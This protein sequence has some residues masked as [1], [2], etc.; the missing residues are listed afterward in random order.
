[1]SYKPNIDGNSDPLH[2]PK[3]AQR[4][5]PAPKRM[6]VVETPP[7]T[8]SFSDDSGLRIIADDPVMDNAFDSHVSSTTHVGRATPE[9]KP[10]AELIQEVESKKVEVEDEAEEQKPGKVKSFFKGMFDFI[11]TLFIAFLVALSFR[12]FV[13][14]LYV[15][16]TGSMLET[17]QEED[18]VAGEK[19]S[20]HFTDVKTGDIITF[21]DP[22]D[23]NKLLIKRVIANEGSVVDLKEGHVFVDG[24]ELFEPYTRGKLSEPEGNSM[25]LGLPISYP[26]TVPEGSVWVMGDNRDN[27][28]DSRSFGSINKSSITSKA[29]CIIW[30]VE[31]MR[32]L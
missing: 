29:L 32:M 18:M 2:F 23:P 10:I 1:M 27:S 12:Y 28:L 5:R 30:P 13:F 16:P 24:K 17:I 3:E 20:L 9:P 14:E 21:R 31:D 4:M 22:V 11:L 8:N 19:V 15:V 6:R 25:N 26:Y 7:Q